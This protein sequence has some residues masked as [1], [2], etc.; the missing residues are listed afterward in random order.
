SLYDAADDDSATGGPDTVRGLFPIVYR[1]DAEGAVR[2]HDTEVAAV[3]QTVVA[4]RA[5]ANQGLGA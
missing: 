4:D 1:V 2:L 5:A 3:A